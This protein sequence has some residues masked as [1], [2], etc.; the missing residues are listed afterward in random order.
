[1]FP[2]IE[3]IFGVECT[4]EKRKVMRNVSILFPWEGLRM[5]LF[6]PHGPSVFLFHTG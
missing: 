5:G 3:L 6:V 4:D 1:M 2:L